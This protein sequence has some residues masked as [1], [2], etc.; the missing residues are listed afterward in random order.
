MDNAVKFLS[1]TEDAYTVGGY[2]VIFGGKDLDGE[3]FQPDTDYN[4]DL[5]PAKPVFY[6]H[7]MGK[8][9]KSLGR[10][11]EAKGDEIGIWVEAELDRS[12]QYV[13]GV[14]SLVHAGALGWSS[15]SVSH[16]VQRE[17]GVIKSWPVVEFSLTPTPAEPR[18]LGVQHIKALIEYLPEL[19][20]LLEVAQESDAP[21]NVKAVDESVSAENQEPLEGSTM[22]EEV[23]AVKEPAVVDMSEV[24]GA[25]KS[26]ADDVQAVKAFQAEADKKAVNDP[27]VAMPNVIMEREPAMYG[28]ASPQDLSVAIGVLKSAKNAG[29][30]QR[31]V[32][33]AAY[34][35]LARKLD[36]DE[37]Q[38]SEAMQVANH[39]FKGYGIKADELNRSTLASYG[40]EWAG[41]AYSGALWERVRE[42]TFLINM[43]PQFEFPAG[44]ESMVIPLES[45]D[46]VWYLVGQAASMTANP[47]AYSGPI[48]TVTASRVGTA[49]QTMTLS[50]LGARVI[51]TGEMEEDSIIPFAANL[52]RQLAV[53]GA[54]YLEHALIDGDTATA[55]TTNINDIAGQPG[56]T[57][58]FL[59]FDGLRKIPLV[60]LTANSRDGGS[61]DE[62]DFLETLKLM[63][64]A[65]VSG[66]DNRVFFILDRNTHWK[67]LQIPALKTKDVFTGATL[68]NGRL[69]GIYGH[70]VYVSGQMARLTNGLTNT[71][72]K[73]D[74]DT[75]GNN[76]KGQILAVRPD[77]WQFGWRRRMTVETVRRPESDS[78][79]IVSLMRAGFKY[80][81]ADDAAAITYNITV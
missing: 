19:K 41:V 46:P 69:T 57:E 53:S 5:V 31:G 11:V 17:N 58:A 79:E 27:G 45:T 28:N 24:L 60:T 15:G 33:D 32:S 66:A 74:L 81:A 63:G 56:G 61:L 77:R 22:T 48:A 72:G 13:E 70:K 7:T 10:V 18:T 71:A 42:E 37:A 34:K 40:D 25:I 62:N 55:N 3:T 14:M 43:L 6:D 47:G 64:I 26:L 80:A 75:G 54:E 4:L 50:K 65:G 59:A 23:T 20:G 38:K 51:W 30:S 76:T 8:L 16:L 29:Q 35:W 39:A 44:A 12:K 78:T 2:G 9:K 1:A 21:A 36:S 52:S 49:N 73:S 67:A 68:E